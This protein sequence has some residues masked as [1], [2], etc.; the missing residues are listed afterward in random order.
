MAS[1]IEYWKYFTCPECG[2]LFHGLEFTVKQE[3]KR[4]MLKRH[5]MLIP[6]TKE[7]P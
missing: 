4:H 3:A 1:P 2:K 5:V 6:G 7:R